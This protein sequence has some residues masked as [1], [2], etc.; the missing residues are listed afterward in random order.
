MALKR[1]FSDEEKIGLTQE[2][3]KIGQKYLRKYKTAGSLLD[4]EALKLYEMYL[5]GCSFSEINKQYPA[6]ELGQVI[7]TAA[8]KRWG[9]DRDK[10]QTTLK[11]RVQAKIVK[12]VI[13]QV[14]FLTSMLEV[15]SAEHINAMRNYIIDPV[16]NP[17]PNLR[18]QSIKEYKDIM[19]AL[20]KLVAGTGSNNK[21]SMLGALNASTTKKKKVIAQKQE[22]NVIELDD[23]DIDD[24]SE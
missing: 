7:L 13:E 15:T 21:G 22:D 5:I 12:S 11:D 19:E 10:M 16:N 2:E 4:D 23:I 6:Y 18:I 17:K 20:Q 8:L 1:N 3:I 24:G 14:D 9:M